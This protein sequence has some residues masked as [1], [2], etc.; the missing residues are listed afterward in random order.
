MNNY[1]GLFGKSLLFGSQFLYK[2]A[3]WDSSIRPLFTVWPLFGCDDQHMFN[4]IRTIRTQSHE[5][6]LFRVLLSLKISS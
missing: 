6:S 2:L 1:S 4:C 5:L 3:F